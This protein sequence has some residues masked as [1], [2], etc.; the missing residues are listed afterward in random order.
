MLMTSRSILMLV[1][2]VSHS[3]LPRVSLSASLILLVCHPLLDAMLV[4]HPLLDA[5]PAHS[6]TC[7]CRIYFTTVMEKERTVHVQVGMN[8]RS[9]ER[10]YRLLVYDQEVPAGYKS[11]TPHDPEAENVLVQ[12][13][14]LPSQMF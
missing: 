10:L 3:C 1:L 14:G 5:S 6:I 7:N 2:S 9:I 4:C 11:D 8:M 13:S 12:L